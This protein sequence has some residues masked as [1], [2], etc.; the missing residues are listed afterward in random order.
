MWIFW[1]AAAQI[2]GQCG[3]DSC[4]FIGM[5]VLKLCSLPFFDTSRTS[6]M[7]P[8]RE[9]LLQPLAV[10]VLRPEYE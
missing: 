6:V 5:A 3:T 9:A 10:S 8:A 7:L 4:I 1:L 2:S